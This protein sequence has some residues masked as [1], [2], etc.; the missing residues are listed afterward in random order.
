M[1]GILIGFVLSFLFL[2]IS[3]SAEIYYVDATNGDDSYNGLYPEPQGGSDGPWQTWNHVRTQAYSAGD[4]IR[5]KRGETWNIGNNGWWD[6]TVSG[7]AGNYIT[8]EDYGSGNKPILDCEDEFNGKTWADEG[9]NVWSTGWTTGVYRVRL[10]GQD[11]YQAPNSSGVD[12]IK[13]LWHYDGEADKLYVYATQNPNSEYTSMRVTHHNRRVF[14]LNGCSYIKIRNLELHGGTYAIFSSGTTTESHITIENCDIWYFYNGIRAMKTLE[15]GSTN[16]VTIQNC[17]IDSK[18]NL[19]AKAVVKE[20]ERCV[21]DCVILQNE[22]DNWLI[23]NNTIS[24]SG[25]N[26]IGIEAIFGT[27]NQGTNNNVIEYNTFDG[28]EAAYSRAMTTQGKKGKCTGNIY[29]YNIEKNLN[30]RTQIG[31]ENN[32]YYHNLIY[33]RTECQITDKSDISEGFAIHNVGGDVCDGN[34]IYNNVFYDIFNEAINFGTGASNNLVKNNII[35]N[36]G[37]GGDNPNIGIYH[38]NWAGTGNVISNNC[39][40]DSDASDVI[41]YKTS[42]TSTVAYADANY[43]EFSDNVWADP[44]FVDAA[45]WDFH[46]QP[47]SPCIDAGTD[48][49]LT[50]DFEGNPVPQGN[51]TDIGAYE[52]QTPVTGNVYY[53]D[54]TNGDDSYNGLYPTFQGG[55]DG[56]WQTWNHVR[57]QTYSPGDHVKFKRGETWTIIWNEY[58]TF[59]DDGTADDYIIIEDYGSGT[60]PTFQ[61]DTDMHGKTWTEE[62]GIGSNIWSTPW[63]AQ[64][65][66]CRLDNMD[67]YMASAA[68]NVDGVD[69]IWHWNTVD[70]KL[71]VYA[72][73]NPNIEY[74]EIWVTNTNNFMFYIQGANYVKFQNL[75]IQGGHYAFRFHMTTNE[76]YIEINNCDIWYGYWPIRSEKTPGGGGSANYITIYGNDFDSK[77]NHVGQVAMEAERSTYNAI[78]IANEC[79][80]WLIRNNTFTGWSHGHVGIMAKDGSSQGCHNNIIE[81]NTFDGT[82]SIYIRA[83]GISGIDGKCTNNIVRYNVEKNTNVRDQIG[84]NNNQVYYNLIYHK[85]ETRI[86]D[87][88]DVSEGIG[89]HEIDPGMVCDGVKVYNN[90]FYDIFNQGI[91]IGTD[92][93]NSVI[94]NNIIM[95]TGQG[96][97]EPNI[98][99]KHRLA[100]TSGNVIENNCFYDSDTLTVINYK[101]QG[102]CTVAYADANYDEF[103]DNVWADPLFVDAANGNF[104]LQPGS[105]C[106][107]AG[108]DVGL[109]LDFEGNPVPKGNAPD[110]GAYEYLSGIPGDLDGD[111]A[112]DIY[113]LAIITTHFG[114]TES[115]QDW[116]ATVDVVQN[117][118]IDVFDVV[119]VASRFT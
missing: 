104:H 86:T 1:R 14:R 54:A 12:G 71:F 7:T 3:V 64:I 57:T 4:T 27:P 101:N 13:Y 113:D 59:T 17:N 90:I 6:I 82:P 45:N 75:R 91:E 107:D 73:Q 77:E 44:L 66:R 92:A 111:G 62:T 80:N 68:A 25:H 2:S 72:T 24:N 35:V 58:W 89:I 63:P 115:H 51:G 15:S 30:V 93:V 11:S 110:I 5:F 38:A 32:E 31:G 61:L 60:K 19:I 20:T 118:E 23:R 10:D 41:Y 26:C 76:S 117:Y 36:A 47:N 55:S 103:S 79:S 29:R 74:S 84:G 109:T 39:I 52:Y 9:G 18:L 105:P 106:I 97:D 116:N 88:S 70:N 33:H 85:T 46:L 102:T 108:T 78:V 98:C 114:Q 8:I 42:G 87:K 34:K 83:F 21:N 94:K 22:C 81:Y 16:Y 96:G 53:V 119:F 50:L 67:S 56:P 100:G 95:N 112:I 49:G 48:V 69:Y 99:L 28:S 37:Q 40:Y 43:E 65:H